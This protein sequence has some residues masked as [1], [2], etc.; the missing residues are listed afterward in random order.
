[1][2][3]AG[4]SPQW[5][6]PALRC[7]GAQ[8]SSPL[9][10]G[11]PWG[12]NLPLLAARLGAALSEE[13]GWGVQLLLLPA[14][15]ARHGRI[16]GLVLAGKLR[17]GKGTGASQWQGSELSAVLPTQAFCP[18][19]CAAPRMAGA[20]VDFPFKHNSFVWGVPNISYVMISSMGA[21]PGPVYRPLC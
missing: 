12:F 2:G 20:G 17:H 19:G 7:Q 4:Q 1:M 3:D 15:G 21:V 10:S 8:A 5:V 13:A 11:A 14:T 18:P 9:R 16:K 6:F